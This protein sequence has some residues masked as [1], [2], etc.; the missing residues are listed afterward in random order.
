MDE[1]VS[2]DS[3]EKIRDVIKA[4]YMRLRSGS[5]RVRMVES[6]LHSGDIGARLT[7]LSDRQIGQLMFNHVGDDFCFG[8]PEAS[9]CN[10]ATERLF[11]SKAGARGENEEFNDPI[12]LPDCPKCGQPMMHYIGFNE[13]DY[14]KCVSLKC[15]HKIE[16]PRA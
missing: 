12:E 8:S 2:Q 10:E 16:E 7:A 15:E 11:R 14:R 4:Q 6:F 1:N 13:P 3:A 5:A 9:I